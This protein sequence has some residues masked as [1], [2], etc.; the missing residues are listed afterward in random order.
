MF[1]KPE[2]T[3]D[4]FKCLAY[5]SSF[6]ARVFK[7]YLITH[8]LLQ[9]NRSELCLRSQKTQW[10]SLNAWLI[11]HLSQQEYVKVPHSCHD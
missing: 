10:M 6:A 4:V 9:L 1:E 3:V 2:N 5:L 7:S 11:F 8:L